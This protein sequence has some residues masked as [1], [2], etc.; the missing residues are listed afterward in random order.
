MK[1]EQ[2][3]TDNY[4]QQKAPTNEDRP[5]GR[6][7]LNIADKGH[8]TPRGRFGRGILFRDRE[9]APQVCECCVKGLAELVFMLRRGTPKKCHK[10]IL[11]CQWIASCVP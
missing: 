5:I 9:V 3:D 10:K 8:A 4:C 1:G 7:S 11:P 2:D 6:Q